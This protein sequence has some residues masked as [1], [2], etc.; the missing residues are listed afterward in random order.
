[1]M[2]ET[3]TVEDGGKVTLPDAVQARYGFE[4]QTPVRLIETQR[5]VLLIPL[6]AEP[7]DETLQAE[8]AEWQAL[9]AES[10]ALFPFEEKPA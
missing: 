7:M 10:L 1:M 6:T 2:L 5:G 3:L 9:G 8:L 4:P